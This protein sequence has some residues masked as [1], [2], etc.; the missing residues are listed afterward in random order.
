MGGRGHVV[1]G[2][3]FPARYSPG[4]S[5][6]AESLRALSRICRHRRGGIRKINRWIV[7]DKARSRS[8]S[9]L[10]VKPSATA[11]L[12][13]IGV[14]LWRPSRSRSILHDSVKA[15]IG[16]NAGAA[17]W[18]PEEGTIEPRLLMDAVLTAARRRGVEIRADCEVSGLIREGGRCTGVIAGK[19]KIIAAH[20]VIS[21]GCFSRL[22]DKDS[23]ILARYVPTRPVRGQMISLRPEGPGLRHVLRSKRGY[24]V[25]RQDGRIA[26]GS[27]LE[28]A[29]FDKRVTPAGIRRIFDA[30][31]ELC[32]AL[33]RSAA[34]R[35]MVGLAPWHSRR[36]ADYRSHRYRWPADRNG[37]LS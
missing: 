29:G 35:N 21:A 31:L 7:R 27:T 9:R 25:P 10:T 26:A 1:P 36:S 20:V 3:G 19:E 32:P 2:A 28:E 6:D 11:P 22:I 4:A 24:L 30:A 15:T 12:K 14:W 33:F 16:D 8:S 5:P 37:P 18:L 34:G 23:D 17:A 13:N